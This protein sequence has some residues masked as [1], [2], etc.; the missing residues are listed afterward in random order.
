MT[1]AVEIKGED[2]VKSVAAALQFISCYHPLDYLRHLAGAYEREESPAAKDA[3][4]QILVNSRMAALGQ[5]PICQDTGM[6]VAFAKVGQE[7]RIASDRSLGD[8]LNEAV[9][10]A[11]LDPTNPLRA[12]MVSDPLFDRSNTRDNAPAVLHTELIP[13]RTL[14][15]KLAAKGG[16]SENKA[17]FTVLDPSES[18]M[19]WVLKTVPTLGAGWCPPGIISVGIGGSSE[20]AMLL[21]KEAMLEP[22]DMSE[23]LARGPVTPVEKLRVELYH[24]IN[25]LGI[26]AQGLGGLTTVVDVKIATYPTHCASKP[27]ALIPQC[28]ADRHAEIVLDGSGP[29]QLQPPEL[30]DWPQVVLDRT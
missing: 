8:L 14:K 16:G 11:Y 19:N 12:S 7:V 9:R 24:R 17:R 10:R 13:G 18:V 3:I 29:V 20:K 28:A 6:V 30:S 5:R 2:I 23:L 22:I 15:I 1:E 26:G 27:V 4:A 21:A 25:A